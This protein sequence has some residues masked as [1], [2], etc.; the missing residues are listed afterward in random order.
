MTVQ[1]FTFET[2]VLVMRASKDFVDHVS[3][4]DNLPIAT[5]LN[6]YIQ[7]IRTAAKLF[8]NALIHFEVSS[9]KCTYLIKSENNFLTGLW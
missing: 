4:G 7:F 6:L 9:I 8:P 5:N 1:Y 2:R 3:C